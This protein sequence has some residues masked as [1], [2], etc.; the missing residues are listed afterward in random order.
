VRDGQRDGSMREKLDPAEAA[1][2]I[3]DTWQ[4]AL[5]RMHVEKDVAP[6]RSAAQFLR[7]Y[8]AAG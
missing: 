1:A 5:Q 2:A 6:L 3:Q 8:L 4:G 7:S